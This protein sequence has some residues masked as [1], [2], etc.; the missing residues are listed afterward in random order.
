MPNVGMV[1]TPSTSPRSSARPNPIG[2]PVPTC[3]A[4][5]PTAA[6]P[7]V[8]PTTPSATAKTTH[9]ATTTPATRATPAQIWSS[10]QKS[11]YAAQHAAAIKVQAISRSTMNA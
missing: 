1:A 10:R 5:T 2:V 11:S 9:T 3:T 4:R 8:V 6:L 7:G